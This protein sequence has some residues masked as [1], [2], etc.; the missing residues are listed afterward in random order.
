MNAWPIIAK[1]STLKRPTLRGLDPSRCIFKP[2]SY[3]YIGCILPITTSVERSKHEYTM[4]GALFFLVF[5]VYGAPAVM[6]SIDR[7]ISPVPVPGEGELGRGA[8]GS[9][10]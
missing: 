8:A 2:T 1:S 6:N 9:F 7:Y 4:E 3:P 5:L 10:Q